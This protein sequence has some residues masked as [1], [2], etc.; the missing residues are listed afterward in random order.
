[1]IDAIIIAGGGGTKMRPFTYIAPK[2]LL[3][4]GSKPLLC[5]HLEKLRIGGIREVVVVSNDYEDVFERLRGYYSFRF[6]KDQGRG[7]V[8]ALYAAIK[9]LRESDG[10]L[11]IQGN[12]FTTLDYRELIKAWDR[13]SVLVALVKIKVEDAKRFGTARVKD[14]QIV[15]IREKKPAEEN[16]ALA[17][18]G[19]YLFPP[20]ILP[21]LI[22]WVN[23]VR[24]F[25][26]FGEF[27]RYLLQSRKLKPFLIKGFWEYADNIEGYKRM[28][29]WWLENE[30]PTSGVSLHED[31]VCKGQLLATL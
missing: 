8:A 9:E 25:H 24:G 7:A 1:M 15:E 11:M 27:L 29:R 18:A 21:S 10:Y 23:T 17:L 30:L 2:A 16:S 3:P 4:L 22:L 14:G 28:W 31:C 12:V 13:K 26:R 5:Y 6:V 19:I 20:L